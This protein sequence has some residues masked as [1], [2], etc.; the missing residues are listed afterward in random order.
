MGAESPIAALTQ[1]KTHETSCLGTFLVTHYK[2]ILG[3]IEIE[4]V[5]RKEAENQFDQCDE[6]KQEENEKKCKRNDKKRT[7][8]VKKHE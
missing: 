3:G 2:T 1:H 4:L 5:T 8:E 7:K 6:D